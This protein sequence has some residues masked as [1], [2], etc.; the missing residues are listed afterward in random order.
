MEQPVGGADGTHTLY[1]SGWVCH[2]VWV[3][4]WC[5]QIDSSSIVTDY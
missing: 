1:L 4:E 5:I 2:L 3:L